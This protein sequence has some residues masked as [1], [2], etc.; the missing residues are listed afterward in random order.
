M[1]RQIAHTIDDILKTIERVREKTA[2]KTFAA[3]ES[4][5]ELQFIIQ[6]AI[7]IISEATRRLPDD[8]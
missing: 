3:Y 4:D 2:S 5:W 8:P 6:R 7:E 1:Q